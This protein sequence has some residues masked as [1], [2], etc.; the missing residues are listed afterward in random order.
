MV[1]DCRTFKGPRSI[2]NG[3]RGIKHAFLKCLFILIGADCTRVLKCSRD[4]NIKQSGQHIVA[5]TSKTV[6]G[7]IEIIFVL[8][9]SGEHT[10]EV[11]SSILDNP[12][13]IIF[14]ITRSY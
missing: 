6:G 8:A 11:C 13:F 1:M 12:V 5:N 9:C 2:T 10:P 7:N 4:K 14:S 3:L